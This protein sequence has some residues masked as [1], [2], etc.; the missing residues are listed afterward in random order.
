MRSKR[1]GFCTGCWVAT[2]SGMRPVETQKSTVAGPS[3]CRFGARSVPEASAPWQL[4]QFSSN[5]LW[6]GAMY[7]LGG[8]WYV[9]ALLSALVADL[10]T[11]LALG[12]G[13]GSV[14]DGTVVDGTVVEG[15]VV[16]GTVVEVW[17][18]VKPR[19]PLSSPTTA[20]PATR[21]PGSR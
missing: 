11:S 7:E 3:P 21:R 12:T 10:S 17:P 4:E 14:V 2:A 9:T 19:A 6:P 13:A 5:R 16:E 15:T 8:K 20:T 1:A 18:P